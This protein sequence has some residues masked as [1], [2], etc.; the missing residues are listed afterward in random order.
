MS[1]SDCSIYIA[2]LPIKRSKFLIKGSH[3]IMD[4][5]GAHSLGD[6]M[7]PLADNGACAS[8]VL[9]SNSTDHLQPLDL[10]INQLA[11]DFLIGTGPGTAV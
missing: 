9:P 6:V 5:F 1:I 10:C 3:H 2:C 11:K 7:Q 4:N 8:C